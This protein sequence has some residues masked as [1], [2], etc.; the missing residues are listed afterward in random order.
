MR[1][2]LYRNNTTFVVP[3]TADGGRADKKQPNIEQFKERFRL[4]R[5][6]RDL[7]QIRNFSDSVQAFQVNVSVDNSYGTIDNRIRF[8]L[9]IA[10]A[11]A[12]NYLPGRQPYLRIRT[13]LYYEP[14]K[15]Y[16]SIYEFKDIFTEESNVYVENLENKCPANASNKLVC[17]KTLSPLMKV[18]VI[19]FII[20][21]VIYLH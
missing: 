6:R 9:Q 5:L 10:L 17:T 21:K 2:T 1:A 18:K 19:R 15:Y 8:I 16:P 4:E 20:Y 14:P 11:Q 13:V 3:I 12:Y 7:P